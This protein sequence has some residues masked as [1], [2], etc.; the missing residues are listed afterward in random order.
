MQFQASQEFNK[1]LVDED[2]PWTPE[3]ID[4]IH[5]TTEDDDATEEC[6]KTR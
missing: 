5:A 6:E 2:G 3:E 4:S 1:M